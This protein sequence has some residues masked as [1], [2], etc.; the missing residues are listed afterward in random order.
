MYL[1]IDADNKYI[2]LNHEQ[3]V[4]LVKAG[5]QVY[6]LEPQTLSDLEPDPCADVEL[7]DGG[8]IEYPDSGGNIRRRDCHGNCE[9]MRSIGDA[10]WQEWADLWDLTPKDF[11]SDDDDDDDDS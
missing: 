7:M 2:P 10:D 5:Q 9:E 6:S 1:H 8:C 3:A 11:A 4:E